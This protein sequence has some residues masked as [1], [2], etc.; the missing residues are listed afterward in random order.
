MLCPHTQTPRIM[1][2]AACCERPPFVPAVPSPLSGEREAAR[3][4]R[5]ASHTDLSP[6]SHGTPSEPKAQRNHG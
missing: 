1:C 4:H 2:S 3:V 5:V 6:V